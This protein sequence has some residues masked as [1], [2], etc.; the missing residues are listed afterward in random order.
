MSGAWNNTQQQTCTRA[1][2][3]HDPLLDKRLG[4]VNRLSSLSFRVQLM[5]IQPKRPQLLERVT[6]VALIVLFTSCTF[7][8]HG[9]RTHVRTRMHLQPFSLFGSAHP[10]FILHFLRS[11][12]SSIFT[13]FSFVS[14]Y[15]ITPPQLRSSCLSMS[16]HFHAL[17]RPTPSF[18][19]FLSTHLA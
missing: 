10:V 12:A 7:D 19:V 8:K 3:Q 14:S 4:N 1:S 9:T 15:N 18:S 13:P 16:T 6:I 17:I 5:E 2:A 11:C